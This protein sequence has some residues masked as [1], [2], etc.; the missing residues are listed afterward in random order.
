MLSVSIDPE[1]DTPEVLKRYW[2]TFGSKPGWYYLTGD[3]DEIDALR[4]SLGVYD[5][6]PIIDA[7]KTQHA[8]LITFGNDR[9][10]RWSALPALMDA[11]GIVETIRRITRDGERRRP[12]RGSRVAEVEPDLHRGQG[13]E[14]VE[15]R[16]PRRRRGGVEQAGIF[17][18]LDG[19]RVLGEKPL[20]CDPVGVGNSAV[21][22]D[23]P[24]GGD[25]LLPSG[26]DAKVSVEC[27]HGTA[28]QRCK[29]R[30]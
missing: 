15:V 23:R 9:T 5:L 6:D 21:L 11:R 28:H 25:V 24:G 1:Q 19:N 8:G 10:N 13:G 22:D 18:N 7:D 20:D 29:T 14:D 16:V 30:Q 26:G 17:G 4:R 3:Y 27:R 2:E 12:R